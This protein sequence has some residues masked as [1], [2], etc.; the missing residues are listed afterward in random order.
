MRPKEETS[1][2]RRTEAL[3]YHAG[4][5]AG[6]IELKVSKPCL[7]PREMRLAYLPGAT[8][9]AA[10]IVADED[11]VYRYTAR[12]NLVGVITNGSAVPGVGNVGAA[13]AKP[14]QEGIA[15]LFKRLADIDVFDL[16]IASEDP[17]RFVEAVKVL[18]PT[19]GAINLKDIRAPEG[20]EIYDRLCETMGIPVF[21]ENLYSTAVVAVAALINALDLTDR[22][23]GET[24]VVVCGA[25]SV[26]IGCARLIARLGVPAENMLLYDEHGL[27]HP[28]RKDLNPYQA[29]FA[30]E[31]P[32]RS[33]A[34]GLQ[35]ADV[36]LGASA[37]GI[38]RQEMI[39]TMNR[40]PVVFAM[41]TPDPEISY[42]EARAARRDVIVATSR[43][44]DPNALVDLLSFPYIFRGALDVRAS[45]ITEG[46]MLAAAR[47]LADLAREQVTEEVSRAYGNETFTFGPE[48][49]LPKPI[50]PRILVHESAAVARRAIADGVARVPVEIE[51]YR[52]GLTV[53]LGTGRELLRELMLKARLFAPRIVFPE[54][55]SETILRASALLVD[56]G[57]ANPILL[58]AEDEVRR[59]GERL[60]LDLSGVAVIDPTKSPRSD[61]Y[62]EEYFRLRAR[63][64]VTRDLAASR[65]AMPN[66]FASL[67]LRE[68]DADLV[69]LGLRWHFPQSLGMV[70]EVIGRADG[71]R[72]VSS[73][74]MILRRKEVYC[75]A[76]CAVNIEPDAEDLAEIAVLAAARV[77][78]LGIE[79][80]VAMLSF[81]DFGSVDHPLARKVR[82]ATA[83]AREQSPDL[84]IEG[85]I[86][87]GTA[88]DSETRARYFPFS[89]LRQDA[90]VLIFPDLQ[91][92]NLALH[93]LERLGEC[94]SVGPVL[95]GT[96]YPAHVLQ[97]GRTVTDVVNLAAI[98]AVVAAS[99]R[100]LTPRAARTA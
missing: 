34:E 3:E 58:G 2:I 5:R 39:R 66:Y 69:I 38:L 44:Q 42:E 22:R 41:A 76:D 48:Y 83:R 62:V 6:K 14:M 37:G 11:A 98:G 21:H 91:S 24:R 86:Q 31:S 71:V 20:L 96:R 35:G 59:A 26:G 30:R 70:L 1:M 54:G 12:G 45:R 92:G 28:D 87:L 29:T 53:R 13:A 80:R 84:N 64:G 57:I 100:S 47:A 46:M 50:D 7:T 10:E 27:I 67:M 19:F 77:R 73:F 88:L 16:E 52:E 55:T 68:G 75:L 18:E 40:F 65:V 90:N 99:E 51:H 85:E 63:R 25:G 17:D 72:R 78:W 8:I 93:L 36:F 4:D 79:P 81:S 56:D 74:H 9:P 82:E 15:V 49:L 97:H 95:M 23:V 89:N 94:V 61:A 33:L 43:G 60:G 32:A